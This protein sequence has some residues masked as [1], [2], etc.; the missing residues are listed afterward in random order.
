MVYHRHLAEIGYCNRG[1]R[2]FCRL[3]GI[4]WSD[5]LDNGIAA[6]RLRATG[7]AQAQALVDHAM[8]AGGHGQE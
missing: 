5:F 3:N 6:E 8:K 2:L 4:D 1:A 7:D